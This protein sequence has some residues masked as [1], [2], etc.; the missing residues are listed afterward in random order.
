MA[1][2]GVLFH[3][4][5]PDQFRTIIWRRIMRRIP[6]LI[7]QLFCL[8]SFTQQLCWGLDLRERAQRLIP[9]LKTSNLSAGLRFWATRAPEGCSAPAKTPGSENPTFGAEGEGQPLR[10]TS[11][12]ATTYEASEVTTYAKPK[13]T[14]D[15]AFG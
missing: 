15:R 7:A 3:S 1:F 12:R 13:V 11:P 14:T 5:S 10:S 2:R 9:A 6:C 8:I 4:Y